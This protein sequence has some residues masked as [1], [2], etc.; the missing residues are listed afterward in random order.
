MAVWAGNIHLG[1][2]LVIQLF[3][4]WRKHIS[5]FCAHFQ[6][7]RVI[8]DS[9][10][11]QK[12][13]LF[14]HSCSSA[15]RSSGTDH[16]QHWLVLFVQGHSET[17]NSSEKTIIKIQKPQHTLN[18]KYISCLGLEHS[19]AIIICVLLISAKVAI[20]CRNRWQGTL[21]PLTSSQ[22][23]LQNRD[24]KSQILICEDSLPVGKPLWGFYA[25]FLQ[26]GNKQFST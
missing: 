12:V 17:E 4:I 2:I 24:W 5:N 7:I 6:I 15:L 19:F 18:V 26:T 9:N 10:L 11:I 23:F 21:H 16:W 8:N 14:V 20:D 25:N 13:S 22:V 3:K 1:Q